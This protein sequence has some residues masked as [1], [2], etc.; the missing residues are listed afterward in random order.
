MTSFLLREEKDSFKGIFNITKEKKG[1]SFFESERQGAG[2][3]VWPL[4]E[5]MLGPPPVAEPEMPPALP[6]QQN[7]RLASPRARVVDS[8]ALLPSTILEQCKGVHCVDLG[9]SFQ[10]H[11]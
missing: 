2:R 8:S 6:P 1:I 7:D 10:T 3:F 5:A 9:E 11:I 4:P